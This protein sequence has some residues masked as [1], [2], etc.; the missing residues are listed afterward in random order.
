[1]CLVAPRAS[2]GDLAQEW[3]HLLAQGSELSCL[4]GSPG[5]AGYHYLLPVPLLFS[6]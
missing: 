6:H 1:M 3:A 5:Q 4:T 2:K